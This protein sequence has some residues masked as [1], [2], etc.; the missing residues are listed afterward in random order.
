MGTDVPDVGLGLEGHYDDLLALEPDA[1]GYCPERA[2]SRG[3][4]GIANTLCH[5][6]LQ[7]CYIRYDEV[8][9][10]SSKVAPNCRHPLRIHRH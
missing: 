3:T 6:C 1:A 7:G 4:A 2:T 10:L 9:V 5:L 8:A